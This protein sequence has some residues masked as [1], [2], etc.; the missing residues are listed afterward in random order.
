M[1]DSDETDYQWVEDTFADRV[2]NEDGV[3]LDDVKAWYDKKLEEYEDER[4]VKTTVQAEFNSWINTQADGEVQMITIGGSDDPFNNGEV[5][6]GYALCI[7]EDD[8]VKLGAVVFDSKTVDMDDSVRDMFYE[9]YTP[10]KGEFDIR[11]AQAPVGDNAYRLDAVETTEVTRF[12]PEKDLDERR[13]MVLDF[14]DDAKIADIGDHLSLTDDRGFAATFG[15]DMRRI[16]EA[17]VHEARIGKAARLVVQDDSFVDAR[18]LGKDVRGDDEEAGLV[19]FAD[20]GL[21]DFDTGSIVDL[22]GALTPNQDGQV[23]MDVIGVD[24]VR[25]VEREDDDG[26]DSSSASKEESAG[27]SSSAGA[28]EERTI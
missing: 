14:V 13:D 3:T 11:N 8:P 24:P 22:Y 19:A 27:G 23:T 5:F 21:V 6:V 12:E 18:D 9:P 2:E 10:G 28:D 4:L 20:T 7:P 16:P 15:V 1:T 17:Y 26:D 25:A